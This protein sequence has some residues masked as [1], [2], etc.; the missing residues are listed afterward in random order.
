M[1]MQKGKTRQHI[2]ACKI[3]LFNKVRVEVKNKEKI[4]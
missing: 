4:L 1:N 2:S 3:D